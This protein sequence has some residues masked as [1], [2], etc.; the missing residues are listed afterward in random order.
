MTDPLSLIK[1]KPAFFLHVEAVPE[2]P[3]QIYHNESGSLTL[4]KIAG[5]YTKT[6]DESYPFDTEIMFGID[7][8]T[9]SASKGSKIQNLNCQLYLKSK[10]N[11]GGIHFTYTG[12]AEH[13]DESLAVF[14]NQ[15]KEVSFTDMY[16][17]MSR[18]VTLSE[19]NKEDF[20]IYGKTLV[21]KG[22]FLRTEAAVFAAE[23]YVYV[24]E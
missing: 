19:N 14:S 4:G 8:L 23:Y 21:G 12:V 3:E 22:R 10:A 17:T 11:G 13:N 1:L 9:S 5:G 15:K 7:N 2:E 16:L 18:T 24:I 6:I 20:W